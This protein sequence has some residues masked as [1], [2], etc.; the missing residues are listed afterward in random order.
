MPAYAREL[1]NVNPFLGT[2]GGLQFEPSPFTVH[3]FPLFG[4][5]LLVSYS[6][7]SSTFVDDGLGYVSYISVCKAGLK[8]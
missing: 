1:D 2:W 8:I 4:L 3:V 6:P 5:L 7:F